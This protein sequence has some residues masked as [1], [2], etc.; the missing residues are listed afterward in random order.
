M[1]PVDSLEVADEGAPFL[2]GRVLDPLAF[3]QSSGAMLYWGRPIAELQSE[4]F[5]E[6]AYDLKCP[7]SRLQRELAECRLGWHEEGIGI[8]LEMTAQQSDSQ[9]RFDLF[10]D[11]RDRKETSTLSRFC[12]HFQYSWRKLPGWQAI[13]GEELTRLAEQ[14]QRQKATPGQLCGAVCARDSRQTLRCWVP[15]VALYGY[16]PDLFSFVGLFWELRLGQAIQRFS[17]SRSEVGAESQPAFW[18]SLRLER[19]LD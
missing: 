1:S 14:E 2:D 7:A 8:Q 11:T 5:L 15:S 4:V 18:T 19:E 10:V 17:L 16:D 12:H 9:C 13:A 6:G 3:F